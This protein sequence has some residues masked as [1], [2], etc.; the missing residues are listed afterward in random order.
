METSNFILAWQ[1]QEVWCNFWNRKISVLPPVNHDMKSSLIWSYFFGLM[2]TSV[3]I[4]DVMSEDKEIITCHVCILTLPKFLTQATNR[5]SRW[6]WWDHHSW[7]NCA[8]W[9][10]SAWQSSSSP[11]NYLC[12]NYRKDPRSQ[13]WRDYPKRSFHLVLEDTK[14]QHVRIDPTICMIQ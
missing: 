2:G 13:P 1:Q 8:A 5:Q 12:S 7:G 14:R 9:G 10:R 3:L 11:T 6:R 4:S